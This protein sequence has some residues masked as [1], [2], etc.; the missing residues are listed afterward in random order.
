MNFCLYSLYSTSY[1]I[2]LIYSIKLYL[3][4]DRYN[5]AW[6]EVLS[7]TQS[8]THLCSKFLMNHNFTIKESKY[9]ESDLVLLKLKTELR[10][11]KS[12]IGVD[13]D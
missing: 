10:W 4:C 6:L 1:C 13:T 9:D 11:Q 2:T 8:R 12:S 5:Q 7:G 3:Y